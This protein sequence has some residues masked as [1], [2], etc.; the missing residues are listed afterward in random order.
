MQTDDRHL[1]TQNLSSVLSD[2]KRSRT[3]VANFFTRHW[4]EHFV[5]QTKFQ[6]SYSIPRV[7]IEHFRAYLTT[8]AKKHRKCLKAKKALHKALARHHEQTQITSDELP[9]IFMD[10]RFSLTQ[11]DTFE[12]VFLEPL[13]GKADPLVSEAE[14][15]REKTP[16]SSVFEGDT[17]SRPE[18]AASLNPQE[19]LTYDAGDGRVFRSHKN[20][21]ER[22]EEY[23]DLVGSLLNN[24]LASKGEAFWT[25]VNSYGSLHDELADAMSRVKAVR[26]NLQ[27]VNEKIYDRT[28]RVLKISRSRDNRQKLLHK[29]QDIACLRDAQITVQMLLN[30]NDYPKALECID[31]AQ[32]VLNSDLKGVTCFRHLNTQLTELHKAIGKMLQEEFVQLIQKEFG[33]PCDNIQEAIYQNG[34]LNPVILGLMRVKEYRFVQV[35]KGEVVEAVKNTLRQI[36]KN[37]ILLCGADLSD[38]DPSLGYGEQMRK[39]NFE[40]WFESLKA[41]FHAFLLFSHRV[42]SIQELIIDNIEA[43]PAELTPERECQMRASASSPCF[44][45]LERKI[46]TLSAVDNQ[47]QP[48]DQS[49]LESSTLNGSAT[50]LEPSP[51]RESSTSPQGA[52][53]SASAASI[54][55]MNCRTASQVRSAV[56]VLTEHALIA[57]E[58]RACRLL[59][60]KSKDGFLERCTISQF[61]EV[62]EAVN[63]FVMK[64]R[65]LIL[66][67]SGAYQGPPPR[68]PLQA[69]MQQ[70]TTKFVARFHDDRKSKLGNIL[71]SELWRS[72]TVPKRFQRIADAFDTSGVLRDIEEVA[73]EAEEVSH[74][75]ELMIGEEKYIVVGTALILMQMVGQYCEVLAALPECATDLLLYLVELLKNFNSRSCQLILGA[76]ALQL[77]GL[78]TISV[79]NLALAS[80]C[81]QLVVRFIPSVKKEF[82]AALPELNRTQLRHVNQ[83]LRDYNDHIS[84]IT[85]KLISV[86]EHHTATVIK[87]WEVKGTIPSAAFQQI[88]KHLGKFYNGLAGVLPGDMISDMFKKT[89]E[90]FKQTMKVHLSAK[91]ITPHDSLTY[92]L[93]NQDYE[94]YLQHLRAIPCC[95]DFPKESIS[96]LLYG[97]ANSNSPSQS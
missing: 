84:E 8:T 40:Q 68:S 20:L 26:A 39:M 97:S 10:S 29:L 61:C 43:P 66:N 60:A 19:L 56:S 45:K 51:P 70:Q 93:V 75:N 88:C 77:V 95:A 7:T 81:L 44:D 91:G 96:E 65:A 28:Q 86:I 27:T 80:R 41:V 4:G 87:T 35:L 46:S 36:V 69:C 83:V 82:E 37:R 74:A 90:N 89:H 6:P 49:T 1:F 52:S 78:K 14:L 71:D 92:G 73:D 72:A 53:L 34:Q 48:S 12:A 55:A 79:K 18:S 15:Q 57:A 25:T 47:S 76:G 64:G 38:F 5:P 22:L 9:L 21:S 11:P 33:R 23:H 54:L 94:Y 13:P 3:E 42:Q 50:S 62:L 59:V 85:N 2:P 16:S 32:E 67:G 30:Q 24:Q 63:E 17:L 58:E 31:T